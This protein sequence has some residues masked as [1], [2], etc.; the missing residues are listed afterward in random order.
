M[1]PCC[2]ATILSISF[3]KLYNTHTMNITVNCWGCACVEILEGSSN[4]LYLAVR[5]GHQF[6]LEC[7]DVV[8]AYDWY[9]SVHMF[10]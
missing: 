8:A 2:R 1:F 6:L 3:E 7:D 4:A 9:E 10:R 5:A